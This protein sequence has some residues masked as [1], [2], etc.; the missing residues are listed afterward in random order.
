MS[1][2]LLLIIIS[3]YCVLESISAAGEMHKG[4]R[5]CR[6]GKYLLAACSG[7]Y[8]ITEAMSGHAT[9]QLLMMQSAIFLCLWPRMVARYEAKRR[10]YFRL[11]GRE[12]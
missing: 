9:W 3:L 7:L 1:F 10:I 4:D 8:A 12:K 2:N 11:Y 5:V 6:V